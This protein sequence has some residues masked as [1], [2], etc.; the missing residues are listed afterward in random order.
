MTPYRHLF[1]PFDLGPLRLRN[2]IVC[3]PLTTNLGTDEGLSTERHFAFWRARARGGAGLVILDSSFPEM[4]GKGFASQVGIHSD[5][6]IPALRKIAT[7]LREEGAAC[8]LQIEHSGA[9]TTSQTSGHVPVAPSAIPDPRYGEVPHALTSAEIESV[10]ESFGQAGRRIK[11]AGFDALEIHGAHGYLVHQFLSPYFNK[12]VD[13]YGGDIGSRTRFAREIIARTRQLV[14]SDYPILFRISAR[15]GLKGGLE[16]DD[17]VRICEVLVDAGVDVLDVSAGIGATSQIMGPPAGTPQGPLVDFAHRIKQTVAIP[18]IAVGR[19]L[20]ANLANEV[21][22]QGKADLVAL[23]RALIADPEWPNKVREE[24]LEEITKCIGCC[25]CN[26]RSRRPDIICLVNSRVGLEDMGEPLPTDAP[27]RVAVVGGGLGGLEAARVAAQR[28]HA[29][30]VW[31]AG[32]QAGGLF[33]LRSKAPGRAEFGDAVSMSLENLARLE[34]PYRDQPQGWEQEL[35]AWAPDQIVYARSGTPLQELPGKLCSHPTL[36]AIDVLDREEVP[37]RR[38][39]VLGGG[40]LGCEAALRLA[41]AGKQVTIA[42]HGSKLAPDTHRSIQQHLI[43]DLQALGVD[44]L[45]DFDS[46]TADGRDLLF[47][48]AD[49]RNR[50]VVASVDTIVLALGFEQAAPPDILQRL[51]T[52]IHVI[53]DAYGASDLAELVRA[54]ALL[55]RA[56]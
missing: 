54:G 43:A 34:V 18:V 1:S 23:G 36:Q 35:L 12:R 37:G 49:T 19:I 53:G 38:V 28:G 29:V 41:K 50:Q 51:D 11:E 21:I 9:Q 52:E 5:E 15:D 6:T 4:R 22:S 7:A 40:V 42:G 31:G 14:G 10:V 55:G 13:D 39:A 32:D 8:A 48:F 56:I 27:K 26:A 46:I 25:G 24:R 17:A 47:H 30:S 44:V 45:L 33:G 3:S 20:D 2:R 16:I